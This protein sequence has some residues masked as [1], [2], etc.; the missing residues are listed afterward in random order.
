[1][2]Y[3]GNGL[4]HVGRIKEQVTIYISVHQLGCSPDRD[5]KRL[6]IMSDGST[7]CCQRIVVLLLRAC[8][9]KQRPLGWVTCQAD[10][11]SDV[12]LF[13]R[14][15]GVTCRPFAILDGMHHTW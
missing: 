2:A 9:A 5:K 7:L 15:G 6:R 14:V 11:S 8:H 1:M 10:A 3:N 12:L 4:K 13:F